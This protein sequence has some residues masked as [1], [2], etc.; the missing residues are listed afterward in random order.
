LSEVIESFLTE[1]PKLMSEIEEALLRQDPRGLEFAAHSLRGALGYLA[2]PEA[3]ED[4][5]KLESAGR[6]GKIEGGAEL[7][8]DLRWR[9]IELCA[10]MV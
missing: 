7:F 5:Q 2:V 6:A 1:S 9:W 3:C 8:L 4:A 10:N